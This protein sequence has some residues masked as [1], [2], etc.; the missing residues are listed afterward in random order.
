MFF[1]PHFEFRVVF[2][3]PYFAIFIILLF[4][5][6]I[7]YFE[8][9]L[10]L[11]CI[12]LNMSLHSRFVLYPCFKILIVIAPYS[13]HYSHYLCWIMFFLLAQVVKT[14]FFPHPTS[15]HLHQTIFILYV[16]KKIKN[17]SCCSA[18]CTSICTLHNILTRYLAP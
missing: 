18:G 15:N 11:K 4:Y 12:I 7:S 9:I 2:C 17:F 8:F 3:V 1:K 6:F 13:L 10:M 16:S 14:L 5:Y